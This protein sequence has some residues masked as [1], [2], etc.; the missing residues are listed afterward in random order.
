MQTWDMKQLLKTLIMSATYRQ[1]S[2]VTPEKLEKDPRNRL[3]S[4][5]PRFRL[6]A[7]MVRDQALALA[8]LLSRK[9]HGPS[10]FPP[11]PPGLWQAAFNGQRTWT[12]STGEDRY[13]RGLY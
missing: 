2:L 5:G 13:R 1:S 12:T 11:Q 3:I 4:R 6:E 9:T 7:E 10:V 8:G